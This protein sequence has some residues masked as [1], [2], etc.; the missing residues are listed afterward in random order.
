MRLRRLFISHEWDRDDLY[1]E[2]KAMIG[3]AIDKEWEDVSIPR[4]A[5]IAI[6]TGER[7]PA[8]RAQ[9][10]NERLDAIKRQSSALDSD[11]HQLERE[12]TRLSHHLDELQQVRRLPRLA[13]TSLTIQVRAER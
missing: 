11:R 3:A 2:L 5:A 10:L 4:D 8:Q 13:L 7:A 1:H 6:E 12:S 9:L